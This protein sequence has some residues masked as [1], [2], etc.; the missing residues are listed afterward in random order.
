MAKP[1]KGKI[2][3]DIRDSVADW[4]AFFAAKAPEGAPNVLVVL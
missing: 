4:E 3:L 1:F 2:D